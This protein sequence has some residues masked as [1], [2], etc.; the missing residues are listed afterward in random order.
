MV[1]F[2]CKYVCALAAMFV[3]NTNQM[4][5]EAAA[6]R[7]N[8]LCSCVKYVPSSLVSYLKVNR[9]ANKLL[10]CH[11]VPYAPVGR[12]RVVAGAQIVFFR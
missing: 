6:T 12:R 5:A 1:V 11:G 3:C 9:A 4:T 2:V 7:D 10:G 8:N